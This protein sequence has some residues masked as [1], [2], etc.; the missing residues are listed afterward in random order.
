VAQAREKEG[1][2]YVL[3]R[4]RLHRGADRRRAQLAPGRRRLDEARRRVV[5]AEGGDIV[6]LDTV[7][8]TRLQVT[9]TRAE[10]NPRWRAATRPSRSF[11][12]TTLHRPARDRL[13]RAT[14]R[15][16]TARRE[17]RDTDSQKFVREQEAALIQ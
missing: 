6:V 9:R 17:T 3:S 2:T 16:E 10:S 13:D 5:F 8:R 4:T 15:R 12:R 7:A 1:A 14:H 11:P